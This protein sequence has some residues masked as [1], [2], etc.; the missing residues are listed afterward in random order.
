[1]TDLKV[2]STLGSASVLRIIFAKMSRGGLSKDCFPEAMNTF[3]QKSH[4]C[5]KDVM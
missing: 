3:Q 4:V 5:R 2:L 1:M